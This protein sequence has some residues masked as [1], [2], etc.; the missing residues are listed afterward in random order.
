MA[1]DT[2]FDVSHRISPPQANPNL[3]PAFVSDS[4]SG[5]GPTAAKFKHGDPCEDNQLLPLSR[6][7]DVDHRDRK[8]RNPDR[9]VRVVGRLASNNNLEFM[10]C[11]AYAAFLPRI[12]SIYSITSA[13]VCMSA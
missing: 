1:I 7:A 6:R 3:E 10:R 12:R 9:L 4:S 5:N 2:L 8:K 11:I 13:P